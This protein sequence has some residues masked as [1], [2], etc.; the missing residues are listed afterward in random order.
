MKA[1]GDKAGVI[2]CSR[3][4]KRLPD[5]SVCGTHNATK[6]CDLICKVGDVGHK[7][8]CDASLCISCSYTPD[9]QQDFCPARAKL[10][11]A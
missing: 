7:R 8:T 1:T 11:R 3:G 5:C 4:S 10:V 6:L 2:I 9:G